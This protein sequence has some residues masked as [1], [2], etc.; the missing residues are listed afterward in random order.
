MDYRYSILS[1]YIDFFK[2]N[3]MAAEQSVAVKHLFYTVLAKRALNV[4]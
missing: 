2:Q 1:K 3:T 4:A